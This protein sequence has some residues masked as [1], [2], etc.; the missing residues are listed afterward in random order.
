MTL[1]ELRALFAA[2]SIERAA[3]VAA[4]EARFGDA[5]DTTEVR[6]AFVLDADGASTG[7]IDP[8]A[9]FTA[10]EAERMA[11]IR[12][13]EATL[14]A[15]IGRLETVEREAA[16]RGAVQA[17]DIQFQ[18]AGRADAHDWDN[19]R[20]AGNTEL[21]GMVRT[22]IES[23]P[24]DSQEAVLATVELVERNG[25]REA[26]SIARYV[27]ANSSEDYRSAFASVLAGRGAMGLLTPNEQRALQASQEARAT[28]TVDTGF[29]FP[30]NVDP[31]MTR[32]GAVALSPIRGLATVRTGTAPSHAVN[33]I[34][35]A[36][37]AMAADGA[38]VA[39]DGSPPDA[40]V[41]I[42]AQLLQ[43]LL[44]YTISSAEDVAA[45]ESELS[46]SA[47]EA[48][49]SVEATQMLTG[50]GT[51]TNVEGILVGAT[52]TRSSTA[53]TAVLVEGD[54]VTAYNL[55]PSRH[56]YN[57]TWMGNL[58]THNAARLFENTAGFRVGVAA[59][60]SDSGRMQLMG[61]PFVE[62]NGMDG[63]TSG[64]ETFTATDDILI[65]GDFANAYRVYDRIGMS[66]EFIPHMLGA[67]R[68]PNGTRGLYVRKRFGAGIVNAD[69]LRVIDVA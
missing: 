22:A 23:L 66:V 26:A 63:V 34:G 49:A 10:V 64:A 43:G 54:L 13:E 56:R 5:E 55:V 15:R 41:T 38:E 30:V 31:T 6:A 36:S 12:G 67:N 33:T 18:P 47:A 62:H 27:I 37:F 7:T 29:S 40:S 14:A 28:I 3:I 25:P 20:N 42:D 45:L 19:A 69:A 4:S 65:L 44:T 61:R 24:S 46:Y 48:I 17:G 59:T 68:R 9:G 39:A 16:E 21:R 51:G 53:T 8:Y 60:I 58:T 1:A 50:S 52:V 2:L 11:A 57:L 35:A 32:I